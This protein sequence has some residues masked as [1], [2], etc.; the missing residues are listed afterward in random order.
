VNQPKPKFK[1]SRPAEKQRGY[2]GNKPVKAEQ[3]TGGLATAP[4]PMKPACATPC[5]ECPL[6]RDSAPGYLGGYTPEMYVEVLHSPASLACHSSPGFHEGDIGRQRHCTGVAAYRA[7][8]GYIASVPVPGLGLIPTAAHESTQLIGHD[9][10][11]YF[12]SAAEF[13]AHHKPGQE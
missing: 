1:P 5:V 6:R 2:Y 3:G 9:E 11:N 10:E 12:A 4:E 7:N 13:V 8:V